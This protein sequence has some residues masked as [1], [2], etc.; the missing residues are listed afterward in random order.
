MCRTVFYHYVLCKVSDVSGESWYAVGL[1]FNKV[2]INAN[3]EEIRLGNHSQAKI[4][5]LNQERNLINLL[6][7]SC[8]C[9]LL[10]QNHFRSFFE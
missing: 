6:I 4:Y 2:S 1:T 7:G 3:Q 9:L 8:T 10:L 5:P